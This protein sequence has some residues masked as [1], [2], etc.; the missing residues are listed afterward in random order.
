M[1]CKSPP[2]IL[3]LITIIPLPYG[4]FKQSATETIKVSQI[5]DRNV[6]EADGR[7][8]G[9]LNIIMIRS[10]RGDKEAF[11]PKIASTRMEMVHEGKKNK[12]DSWKGSSVSF[13]RF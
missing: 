3:K 6:P 1:P 5:A 12:K 8:T 10:F 2:T 13:Y 4:N 7:T 11:L 9:S